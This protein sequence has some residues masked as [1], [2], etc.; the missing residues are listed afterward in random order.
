MNAGYE[1]VYVKVY[2]CRTAHI[3]AYIHPLYVQSRSCIWLL[4]V[5]GGLPIFLILSVAFYFPVPLGQLI[6]A[7]FR[8]VSVS[9]AY[10][11]FSD[12]QFL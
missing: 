7:H 11:I 4:R 5:L 3:H 8:L 1:N 10:E 12:C 9:F 2:L 6:K